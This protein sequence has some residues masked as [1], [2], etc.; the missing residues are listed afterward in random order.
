MT[1]DQELLSA[2]AELLSTTGCSCDAHPEDMTDDDKRCLAC[3][4]EK[5]WRGLL[6]LIAK[7]DDALRKLELMMQVAEEAERQRQPE[8]ECLRVPFVSTASLYTVLAAAGRTR[9]T[10]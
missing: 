5:E 8:H 4:A 10:K 7:A 6:L 9:P 2:I 3:R 1:D